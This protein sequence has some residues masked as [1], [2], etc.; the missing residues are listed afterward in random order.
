[1]TLIELLFW[2]FFAI[3]FYTFFGYG[4]LVFF[5]VKVKNVLWPKKEQFDDTFLPEI[6]LIVP[7]YNEADFILQKVENS[8]NLDYPKDKLKIIFVTDG[9]DDGTYEKIKDIDGIMAMHVP[10]RGGKSGAMN[11]AMGFVTTE[12]VV[13]CDANTILNKES[14]REIVKHYQNPRNGAVACEK[15]IIQKDKENASSAGEGLYWKYESFLKKYDSDLYT[16]AGAAGELMS[17]RTALYQHLEPDT[18]LDD[19][20]LTMRIAEKGYRI[21]YEPKAYAMETASMSVK[22]ELKRKVRICAGG[23]QSIM[24]LGNLLN[25]FYNFPLWFIY[26]S[27]KVLRWSLTPLCMLLLLP[28]NILLALDGNIF[29]TLLLIGQIAFYS[30]AL[31]GWYFENRKIKFKAFFVP[32]Y[33]FIMNYSVFA[34]FVRFIRKRQSVR[35]ERAKRA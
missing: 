27:R 28:L 5:L 12:Y 21:V 19:F 26:V 14:L 29:Y 4:I 32:Y 18:L 17:C 22:E 16:T 15:R 33:F 8:K 30:A 7:S 34:G 6:T 25:P 35:W 3:V 2:V 1:M 11:R 31:L 23:W 9:S 13:F 20:M 10:E 24:R